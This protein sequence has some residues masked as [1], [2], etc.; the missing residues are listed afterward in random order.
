MRFLH[1]AVGLCALTV[2][3]TGC[4]FEAPSPAE[5]M[6]T[7]PA[8]PPAVPSTRASPDPSPS[9]RPGGAS[10]DTEQPDVQSGEDPSKHCVIVA[11]GMTTAMLAPLSLRSSTDPHDLV[12]LEQQILDLR[13]KVPADLQ[14]DFTML[15]SSVE[16]PPEGSGTFDEKAF[17]RAM[18]PVQDW[19]GQ[20]CTT[21]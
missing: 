10:P 17:R 1:S 2:G 16:A 8:S 18:V 11:A 5:T 9:A 6:L 7:M 12:V 19:L 3:L 4:S 13:A 20:H 14:D 15:A 21:S